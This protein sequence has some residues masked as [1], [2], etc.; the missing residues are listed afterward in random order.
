MAIKYQASN[1]SEHQQYLW[2]IVLPTPSSPRFLSKSGPRAMLSGRNNLWS[3]QRRKSFHCDLYTIHHLQKVQCNS[4]NLHRT[5]DG[6]KNDGKRGGLPPAAIGI[7][8]GTLIGGLLL[9]ILLIIWLKKRKRSRGFKE[10]EDGQ[11]TFS[12]TE[13]I[14]VTP[15]IAHT[16]QRP[17]SLP[18]SIE[19]NAKRRVVQEVIRSGSPATSIVDSG[20]YSH[21][22]T[23]PLAGSQSQD[24]YSIA[25]T[26][27]PFK[28][29][30]VLI[31]SPRGSVI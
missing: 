2:E 16:P 25:T 1:T 11:V 19:L 9:W 26:S 27:D 18:N 8:V 5:S 4:L 24:P 7:I 13:D 17:N 29:P 28:N 15:F 23:L 30:S 14:K 31:K 21:F 20:T 6:Q 10:L 12:P 3:P 22:Y